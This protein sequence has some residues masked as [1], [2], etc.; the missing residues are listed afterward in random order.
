MSSVGGESSPPIYKGKQMTKQELVDRLKMLEAEYAK[1]SGMYEGGIQ[2]CKYWLSKIEES[3]KPSEEP[4]GEI[5][6]E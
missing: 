3:E 2:D 4:N 6:P 5:K 1:V